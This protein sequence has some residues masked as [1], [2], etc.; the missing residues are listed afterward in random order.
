MW[1][2]H[3]HLLSQINLCLTRKL[4]HLQ[5]HSWTRFS[6]SRDYLSC[7]E[8][9][10]QKDVDFVKLTNARKTSAWQVLPLNII[11]GCDSS[12]RS[13]N[14]SLCVCV[15]VCL[16]V[17]LVTTV[18]QDFCRTSTGLLKDF[19]NST[20]LL[21]DFYRTSQGLLCLRTSWSKDLRTSQG[22]L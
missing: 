10:K 9:V 15:S 2:T 6:I 21:Q 8:R 19:L 1:R 22:P 16:S 18:L 3:W 20:G 14:V 13:P 4:D 17:T 11:F 12:P 5:W 7:C